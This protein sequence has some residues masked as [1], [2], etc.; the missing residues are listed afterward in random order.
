[1]QGQMYGLE[2][3]VSMQEQLYMIH[4]DLN[5]HVYMRVYIYTHACGYVYACLCVMCTYMYVCI[6][7][8]MTGIYMVIYG[9]YFEL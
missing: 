6:L 4:V 5:A 1:M 2:Y 8:R 7:T 9:A 3:D